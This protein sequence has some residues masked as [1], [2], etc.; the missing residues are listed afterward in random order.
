MTDYIILGVLAVAVLT[1]LVT[2]ALLVLRSIFGYKKIINISMNEDLEI[3]KVAKSNQQEDAG[4]SNPELWKEEIGAMEQLLK[5]VAYMK[6]TGN[7]FK[8]MM[9]GK[10][11]IALEIA[12]PHDSEEIFFYISV[13]KK[14]RSSLEKQVHSYFPD[15]Q[16]EKIKDYTVFAPG[17]KT[18]IGVM[19]LQKVLLYL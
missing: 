7:F 13:P 19:K 14:Y 15:A 3:I 9:Y 6:G 10:P 17:S 4:Q 16:V 12:N 2:G 5:T 8:K 11:S 1:S 18:A